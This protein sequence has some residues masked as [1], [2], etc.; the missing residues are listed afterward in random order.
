MVTAQPCQ[1]SHDV[2]SCEVL[3]ALAA[4]GGSLMVL[5]GVE[6]EKTTS[7]TLAKSST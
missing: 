3:S 5:A 4:P 1:Q 7:Q 2:S 6:G